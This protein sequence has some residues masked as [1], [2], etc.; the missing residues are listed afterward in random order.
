MSKIN[1]RETRNK[2]VLFYTNTLIKTQK[3]KKDGQDVIDL[4]SN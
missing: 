2:S 1:H 3:Y 4:F